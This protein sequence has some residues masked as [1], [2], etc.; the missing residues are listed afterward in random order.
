MRP[1][2]VVRNKK[3]GSCFVLDTKWKVLSEQQ[4][5]YGISQ[6]DMY[7][8]FAYQK[9]YD[10]ENV[11]LIYP[12]TNRLSPEKPI[13]YKSKDGVQVHVE[14]VDLYDIRNSIDGLIGRM[15]TA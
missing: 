10:A 13:S 3:D 6:A 4:F 12:M 2:I 7:Q 5:N 9:K 11:R 1:D 15:M 8:M 14:F